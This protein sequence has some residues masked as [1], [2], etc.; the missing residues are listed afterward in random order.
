MT[1]DKRIPNYR[2]PNGKC[3]RECT[4][5][6]GG[7][8]D[9]GYSGF[10][11]H[12]SFGFCHCPAPRLLLEIRRFVVNLGLCHTFPKRRRRGPSCSASVWTPTATSAL[13]PVRISPSSAA[14]RKRIRK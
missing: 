6:R 11:G 13:R 8:S 7:G 4:D 10:F 14:A 2:N 12:S 5:S 3:Q 1:N 9:F